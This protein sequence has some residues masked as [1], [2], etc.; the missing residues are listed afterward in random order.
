M[1]HRS[2]FLTRATLAIANRQRKNTLVTIP[3]GDWITLS[4]SAPRTRFV[5]VEWNG[6]IVKMFT[7]DI[8]DRGRLIE[9]AS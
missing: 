7:A 8:H 9:I 2:Y 5:D 1:P 3:T 6:E 4:A